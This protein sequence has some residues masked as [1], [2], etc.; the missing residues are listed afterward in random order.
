MRYLSKICG[1][2]NLLPKS[3]LNPLRYDL[4]GTVQHRGKLAIVRKGCYNGQE[5]AA[6]VLREPG[7]DLERTNK[8][9]TARRV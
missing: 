9:G 1:R 6:K 2:H 7:G 8:V 4:A 3:V 5:V